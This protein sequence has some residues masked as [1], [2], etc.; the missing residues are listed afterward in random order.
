ME[1]RDKTSSPNQE[2]IPILASKCFSQRSTLLKETETIQ[3]KTEHL[4]DNFEIKDDDRDTFK[5]TL[6]HFGL[7]EDIDEK[8][9]EG[10][11]KSVYYCQLCDTAFM[12]NDYASNHLR[13][14]HKY[15]KEESFICEKRL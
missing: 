10:C 13:I 8:G 5:P 11:I 7:D 3:E 9:F 2:F 12:T 15:T 14:Y 6:T 4:D 1:T